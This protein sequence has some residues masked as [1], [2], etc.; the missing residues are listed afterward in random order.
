M[1]LIVIGIN[2]KTA[3]V[4]IREKFSISLENHQESLTD[5][6]SRNIAFEAVIVSTC[7]RT[8]IYA[9]AAD[10]TALQDW[11]LNHKNCSAVSGSHLYLYK[12]HKAISHLFQVASGFDSQV[13]GESQILGQ[14]KKSYQMAISCGA[15]KSYLNKLFQKS[16]AVA[17]EIR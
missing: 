6:L 3:S 7:N 1:N 5:L 9:V 11:F 4:S 12:D 16:F 17:K 15:V 10:G 14:I 13:I 2:Y 8:E